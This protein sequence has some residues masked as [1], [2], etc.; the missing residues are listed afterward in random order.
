M[1][2][3]KQCNHSAP[4][5]VFLSSEKKIISRQT[6]EADAKAKSQLLTATRKAQPGICNRPSVWQAHLSL[7]TLPKDTGLQEGRRILVPSLSF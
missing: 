3:R 5:E 7:Y 4:Q 6:V 1:T 2:P